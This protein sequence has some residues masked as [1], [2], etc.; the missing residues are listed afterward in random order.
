MDAYYDESNLDFTEVPRSLP[1]WS[2]FILG[3]IVTFLLVYIGVA[4]PLA[5]EL[6]SLRHQVSAL[7]QSVS[8]V[9]GK[10]G[11]A[12]QATSLL[13]T[14]ARQEETLSGAQASVRDLQTLQRQ[15]LA[16]ARHTQE[17]MTAIAELAALKDTLL[18]STER[19]QAA[20]DVM[21]TSELICQRLASAADSTYEALEAGNNLLALR[22]ELVERGSDVT[23]ANT[24]LDALIDIRDTLQRDEAS[25]QIANQRVADLLN[26][27]DAVIGQ[28]DDLA[29]AIM[30]LE[31]M[32]EL[33]SQ[34]HQALLAFDEIK[35][36]MI[37]VVATQ[38][39]L[40]R[41]RYALEPITDLG[42]L[43]RIRPD[44]LREIAKSVSQQYQARLAS[45]PTEVHAMELP[46]DESI[47]KDLFGDTEMLVPFSTN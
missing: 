5:K 26:L 16:E 37:E 29:D 2:A 24:A 25:F 1:S 35:H 15:L 6:R 47:G 43:R 13:A 7:E 9:A 46:I 23:T 8:H 4:R 45:K 36:W 38:P 14:L 30:N 3:G 41:A 33:N 44:Q 18:A 10:Q 39:L 17:A 21:A 31:I 40:E 32:A 19:T 22:E 42:N 28:T 34:F 11:V 12:E 27:K 20:A